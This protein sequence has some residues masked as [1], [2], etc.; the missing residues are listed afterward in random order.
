MERNDLFSSNIGIDSIGFYSPHLFL[1]LKELANA[2]KINPKKYK[3]GLMANEMRIPNTFAGEDSISLGL[4][5]GYNAIL[6]GNINPKEIDA[7]FVGSESY[8]YAVKSI[9]NIYKDL[10]GVSKN[11]FTQDV[12]N[13]CA[14]ASMA[15]LNA[16]AMIEAG[17]I[18]K[19]LVIAVDI[20]IYDLYSPGEPT[21]G[22]GAVALILSRNP[23]IAIFSNTFGK[24]SANINDFFRPEGDR[25]AQVF[26]HYSV[27]AYLNF[28]IEAYDDLISQ[29]GEISAD[30]YLFHAPYA[31]LPLKLMQKLIAERWIGRIEDLITQTSKKKIEFKEVPYFNDLD[32]DFLLSK[33]IKSKLDSKNF[34]KEKRKEIEEWIIRK[35]K[36]TSLPP[37]QVPALFGNMYSSAIWAEFM[38]LV[39]NFAQVNDTIYFGS[40]GSGSTCISGLLKIQPNFKTVLSNPLNLKEYLDNKIQITVQEYEKLHENEIS[41][42]LQWGKIVSSNKECAFSLNYCNEGCIL[43]QYNGLNY[44]PKG[45]SGS[46]LIEFPL[47]GTLT[48]IK[49][50]S[51]D[52]SPLMDGFILIKNKPIIGS[53]MEFELRRWK[54]HKL[55]PPNSP[56]GLLN[57]MPIYRS[58]SSSPYLELVDNKISS[59]I[60]EMASISQIDL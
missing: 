44:C 16:I 27:D 31:K 25:T 59:E 49:P 36:N 56:K 15:I 57:W 29:T 50:Y 21:Q 20:S 8:P 28:Q 6:R 37:L 54:T 40:Y 55:D 46:N 42:N 7:L 23:R 5:A 38:Y 52:L 9:S 34:P 13:A 30:Y 17:I 35:I 48:E 4:K 11:C 33:D 19:A 24:V 12:S 43:S 41:S 47:T 58:V 51:N 60:E 18:K 45:H 10:L 53:T 1:S 2:R 39:E 26:S 22:A 14:A 3:F 32:N